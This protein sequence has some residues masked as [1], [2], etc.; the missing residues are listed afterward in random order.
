MCAT[1]VANIRLELCIDGLFRIE[2]F[3]NGS[4]QTFTDFI[5]ALREITIGKSEC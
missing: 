5:D 3:E 4:I 2:H 1:V